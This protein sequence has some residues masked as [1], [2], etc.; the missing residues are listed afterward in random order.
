MNQ[1]LMPPP[2][3]RVPHPP[4]DPAPIPV[5]VPPQ[6]PL[7]APVPVQQFENNI[8]IQRFFNEGEMETIE[9]EAANQ[10]LV[11]EARAQAQEYLMLREQF[12]QQQARLIY[13]EHADR[14]LQA[15]NRM[16]AGLDQGGY[17]PPYFP[18]PPPI[19]AVYV[20]PT[21]RGTDGLKWPQTPE[22]FSVNSTFDEK[23]VRNGRRIGGTRQ[24]V[25]LLV[26][27]VDKHVFKTWLSLVVNWSR[28][29][30][31]PYA[32]QASLVYHK[33]P[34]AIR[35][36][37]T[38]SEL[39]RDDALFDGRLVSGVA[40]GMGQHIPKSVLDLVVFVNGVGLYLDEID[41]EAVDFLDMLTHS[42][43]PE[44]DL[45]VWC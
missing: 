13:L 36:V 2:P 25:P 33:L 27:P 4:I 5:L 14:T 37:V 40:M 45:V 32:N 6:V 8:N 22:N 11:F 38:S 39:N 1:E 12:E 19:P 18:P 24:D 30:D 42:R 15:H 16:V 28:N 20:P 23:G 34:P 44:E 21:F 10:A 41:P 29:S 43:M 17:V 9:L 3:P 31:T 35:D 26:E 7:Q